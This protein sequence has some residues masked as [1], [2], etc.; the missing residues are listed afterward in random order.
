MSKPQYQFTLVSDGGDEIE[1]S[2]PARFEV[3]PRCEGA[4]SHVNESID[5]NGITQSEMEELGEDFR[6]DY[7]AGHYDVQCTVCKGQRVVAEVDEE[8]LSPK[9][10]KAWE[11]HLKAKADYQRD[12][13]SERWLRMAESGERW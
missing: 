11:Q 4:G 7:L 8:H 9:Q 6:E 12:Y 10:R 1:W 5:G 2:L 13:D 3:C